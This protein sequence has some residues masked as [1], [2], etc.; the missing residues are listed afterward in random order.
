M[1]SHLLVAGAASV[2][3]CAL[4]NSSA[5]AQPT[6][7]FEY[8]V[9]AW[10]VVFNNPEQCSDPGC[11]GDDLEPADVAVDGC[12]THATGGATHD[13]GN[14]DLVA[15]LTEGGSS[16]LG[17]DRDDSTPCL[18]DAEGAEIHPVVR[19]HDQAAMPQGADPGGTVEA[20]ILEAQTTTFDET[21]RGL[22]DIDVSDEDA[23]EPCFLFP[24]QGSLADALDARDMMGRR[25][26]VDVQFAVHDSD[27][28]VNQPVTW[29]SAEDLIAAGI[30]ADD[31]EDLA[32][33]D[34]EGAWSSLFRSGDTV[35]VFIRTS[36]DH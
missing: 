33:T 19:S 27:P 34:V 8:G 22:E 29:N 10:W 31:A 23:D 1:K 26:C 28:S 9:T 18:V 15:T 24:Q 7:G 3:A 36:L 6:P 17:F 5:Q 30:D 35:T 2:C 16:T 4:V 13:G 12:V 21:D 14:V 25:V 32:G 11:G 20:Q